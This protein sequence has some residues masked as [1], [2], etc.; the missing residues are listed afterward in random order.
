MDQLKNKSVNRLLS[1]DVFRGFTVASMILVNN[2]GSWDH[3]FSQLKHVAWHG[4]NFADLVFPFFLWIVGVAIAF[5][6]AKRVD[7]K[8]NRTEILTH[9]FWRSLIL[10]AIG[11]FIDGF[12][13][14]LTNAHA[15]SWSTI[16]IPGILQRIGVCYFISSIIVLYAKISWQIAWTILF[17]ISAWILAK[18]IPVPDFGVGVLEMKGS[19]FWYLDSILLHGHTWAKAP[20]PGFDPEGILSSLPAIATTLF[21][22]LTGHLLLSK[23]DATKKVIWML[24]FGVTFIFL[25]LLMN[26]WIPINKNIW[27]PSF[28]VFTSGMALTI[29]AGCYWLV[30]I[31][32]Y[33]KLFKPCQI[34]GTNALTSF[35]ASMLILRLSVFIHVTESTGATCSLKSYYYKCLFLLPIG[36]EMYSSLA[37]A[38]AF[39]LFMYLIAYA[40]YRAKI[41][42]KA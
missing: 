5:S 19:L 10:F 40:Q 35:V 41:I 38:I 21:G 7:Q 30:D 8:I 33:Q 3:V 36:N 9:I 13:F 15:F 12:P 17:L 34:F 18:T 42:I 20:V 16:R 23:K 25:G 26:N 31:K 37:H 2:P 32:K 39:V 28:A 29:F 24:I 22:V 6:F 11:L 4:C 27:T 14:G 1:L